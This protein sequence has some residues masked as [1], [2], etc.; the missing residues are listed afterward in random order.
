[1][2]T[3]LR[4]FKDYFT[5]EDFDLRLHLVVMVFCFSFL[6]LNYFVDW[7]LVFNTRFVE[8]NFEDDIIDGMFRGK[9]VYYFLF[10]LLYAFAYFGTTLLCI[11][12]TKDWNWLQNRQFWVISTIGITILSFDIGFYWDDDIVRAAFPTQLY[13]FGAR[14]FDRLI[15]LFTNV[16]PL[17]I[18]WKFTKEPKEHFY[19]LTLKGGTLKPY[20][21][22]IVMMLPLLL[23]ASFQQDFL[24][25]Y[26]TYRDY[27]VSRFLDVPEWVTI[28][29]YEIAYGSDFI[30]VELFF[31]G[32]LVLGFVSIIGKK[33]I[34]P[35]AVLYCFIHF[36]KPLGEA[37]S[38]FFG[39]Y[40]LGVVSFYTRN[41]FG[42][43]IVHL[44]IAWLM[45][46][47]AFGQKWL[48]DVS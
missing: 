8:G 47:F 1:M 2:K 32:F 40:I 39:G 7:H 20:F 44:G 35:M 30:S 10:F 41:I 11:F 37:V 14:S 19:G 26:P 24:A 21:L 25:Q 34:L 16:L 18:L 15:S 48:N 46:L 42:G 27:G 33:A 31:R 3:L 38:S 9:L 6:S 36:G 4:Y 13:Y 29:I 12:Y 43:L 17:Y 28:L 5:S 22:M 45:E 23:W